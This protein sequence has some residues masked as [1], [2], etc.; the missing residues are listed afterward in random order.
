MLHNTN[1]QKPT[2]IL[3]KSNFNPTMD[4]NSET[5]KEPIYSEQ[6]DEESQDMY[7]YYTTF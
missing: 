3:F 5:T 4:G 6:T 2:V 7:D 1:R